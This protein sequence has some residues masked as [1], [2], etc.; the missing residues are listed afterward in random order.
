VELR[1]TFDWKDVPGAASYS[2]Q[3]STVSNFAS[4]LINRLTYTSEYV[5]LTDLPANITLYWRVR[6]NGPN[7]P[8]LWSAKWTFRVGVTADLPS[9]IEYYVP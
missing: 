9:I 2:F 3:L 6:A 5:M 1:P 8:S 4:L 7:G